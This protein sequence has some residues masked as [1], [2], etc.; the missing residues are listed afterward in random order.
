[1]SY[2]YSDL[3]FLFLHEVIESITKVPLD[4]Y[5]SKHFY[6]PLGLKHTMY[7]LWKKNMQKQCA[8]SERDN[9][10]RYQLLQGYVH[11]IGGDMF[12]YVWLYTFLFSCSE[13]IVVGMLM[14]N[15]KGI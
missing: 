7:N 1:K 13:L 3:D 12:V 14:L 9:Y 4:A 5:V 15:N 11:D 6:E 2:V 10:F 8:P